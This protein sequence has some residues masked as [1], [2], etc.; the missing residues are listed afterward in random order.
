MIPATTPA[1]PAA[2]PPAKTVLHI[3]PP[4]SCAG[5]RSLGTIVNSGPRGSLRV[6]WCLQ[7]VT[8]FARCSLYETPPRGN[9]DHLPRL[10]T[11]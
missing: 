2:K 7:H 6:T 3:D 4:H 9:P 10:M 1:K 8:P 5:C 11:R